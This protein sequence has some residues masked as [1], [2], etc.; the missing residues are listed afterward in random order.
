VIIKN[1]DLIAATHGRSFWILDDLS[2]LHQIS[3]EA[4][5][6]DMWLFKPS[7]VE[8]FRE[9][10]RLGQNVGSGKKIFGRISGM[11][12][13][14]YHRENEQGDVDVEPLDA[15]KNPPNGAVIHYYFKEAPQGEVKLT[16]LDGDDNIVREFSSDSKNGTRVPK[17]A[18][19][20]R[21][22]WDLRYPDATAVVD[23]DAPPNARL[24]DSLKGPVAPPGKYQV[25]LEASG[26]S[27]T[28]SLRIRKDKRVQAKKSELRDQFNLLIELRD[29]LSELNSTVNDLRKVRGQIQRWMEVTD[30]EELKETGKSLKEQFD[31][32]EAEMVSTRAADP[33]AFPS[34]LAD[35]LGALPPQIANADRPPTNQQAEASQKVMGDAD[36]KIE[37]FRQLMSEEV[38]EFNRLV[39]Q[40]DIPPVVV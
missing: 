6:A 20:N 15:G 8:R 24:A 18:G 4:R 32:L 14:S 23:L 11:V 13:T 35:T 17:A 5:N 29:K 37:E 36:Q 34:G 27:Q 26:Q 25:R 3:D 7:R 38:R 16:I 9:L 22:V 30:D 40:K 19:A 1:K 2:P 31:K 21:F 33:R 39:A 28:R 12:M 10:G